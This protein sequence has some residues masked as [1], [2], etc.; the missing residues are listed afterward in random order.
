MPARGVV[1]PTRGR[2]LRARD[3]ARRGK[4]KPAAS[5]G[6][7]FR[8]GNRNMFA[9]SAPPATTTGTRMAPAIPPSGRGGAGPAGTALRGGRRRTPEKKTPSGKDA[10]GKIARNQMLAGDCRVPRVVRMSSECRQDVVGMSSECRPAVVFASP[11]RRRRIVAGSS[12]GRRELVAEPS[13]TRPGTARA[14]PECPEGAAGPRR[15]RR[16][17]GAVRRPAGCRTVPPAPRAR[18]PDAAARGPAGLHLQLGPG[19]L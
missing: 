18:P 13:R 2:R 11:V 8:S 4:G 3:G 14:S 16:P 12:R 10:R 17:P 15:R 6:L 19:P 5:P 1:R 9:C 7:T